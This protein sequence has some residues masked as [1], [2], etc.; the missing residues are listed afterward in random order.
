MKRVSYVEPWDVRNYARQIPQEVRD[1]F[2]VLDS[3]VRWSIVMYV[4]ENPGTRATPITKM[5]GINTGNTHHAIT[6]L[7]DAGL[8]ERRPARGKGRRGVAF[9]L[10]LTPWGNAF[11][12]LMTHSKMREMAENN[13]L[14][15]DPE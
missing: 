7:T 10:H 15:L 14:F 6:A 5:A 9:D 12:D 8:L 13:E 3:S 4:R 1:A 11:M 2:T